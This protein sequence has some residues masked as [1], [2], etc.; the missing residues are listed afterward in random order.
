M[1]N[2]SSTCA[3][4]VKQIDVEHI[5]TDERIKCI[6]TSSNDEPY[7]VCKMSDDHQRTMLLKQIRDHVS[8]RKGK[9][10]FQVLG[11]FLLALGLTESSPS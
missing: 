11:A 3:K 9:Q 2:H 1:G 5:D 8:K 4:D 10:E 6:S 7:Q